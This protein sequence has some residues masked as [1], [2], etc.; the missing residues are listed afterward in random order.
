MM[1]AELRSELWII[2]ASQ[3]LECLFYALVNHFLY[4]TT[5]FTPSFA[6]VSFARTLR[7]ANS[8]FRPGPYLIDTHPAGWNSASIAVYNFWVRHHLC[9]IRT[10]SNAYTRDTVS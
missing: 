3:Q 10:P 1:A 2:G 6:V 5:L 9:F 4:K 7:Q 8:S